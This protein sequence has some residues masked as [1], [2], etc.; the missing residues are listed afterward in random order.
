MLEKLTYNKK[1]LALLCGVILFLYFGYRFSFSDT[2]KIKEEIV[3]KEKKLEWLKA[4]EKE[5]P[6]IKSK[7]AEIEKAGSVKD[8]IAVRDK[9]TAFISEFAEEHGCLVTEIPTLNSYKGDKLEIETNTFTI[10]GDYKEL[11][12]LINYLESDCKYLARIMSAR[13]FSVKDIQTKKKKLYLTL[14]T[15]TFEQKTS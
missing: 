11:L 10:K 14:V 5:L 13:F 8:S 7:L 15:Q 6:I 12:V 4:K 9:L 3:E 2:F 1:C